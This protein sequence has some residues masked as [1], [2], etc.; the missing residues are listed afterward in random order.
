MADIFLSFAHPDAERVGLLAS[1][2]RRHG[3]SVSG[4]RSPLSG[5]GFG[6]VLESEIKAASVVIVVWSPHS[7]KSDW[8]NDEAWYA[9]DLGKLIPLRIGPAVT[10]T[11]FEMLAALDFSDWNG[12]QADPVFLQLLRSLSARIPVR[13]VEGDGLSRKTPPPAAPVAD[14]LPS[15]AFAI[16]AIFRTGLANAA[17]VLRGVART[18]VAVWPAGRWIALS[19]V[20]LGGLGAGLAFV[21]LA[22]ENTNAPARAAA[23]PVTSAMI[24]KDGVRLVATAGADGIA[25]VYR[26]DT[27]IGNI[28]GHD[29]AISSIAFAQGGDLVVTGDAMGATQVTQVGSLAVTGLLDDASP[30]GA[31]RGFAWDALEPASAWWLAALRAALP[32]MPGPRVVRLEFDALDLG[33]VGGDA[34][35]RNLP[36]AI[37][38]GALQPANSRLAVVGGDEFAFVLKP[39]AFLMQRNTHNAVAAFTLRFSEPV[40]GVGFRLSDVAPE[41][42]GGL[43]FPGW[44]VSAYDAAG[45]VVAQLSGGLARRYADP[46]APGYVLRPAAGVRIVAVRFLSDP[47][48]RGGLT[49]DLPAVPITQISVWRAF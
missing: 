28:R 22:A 12:R 39:A 5:P 19:L 27:L 24:E 8:V 32:G 20:G 31:L 34:L 46:A 37:G 38:I 6:A 41:E 16:S 47:A 35:A 11:G 49:P 3:Y 30:T 36:F 48:A 18:A 17:P 9:K 4:D 40:A 7:V 23:T 42:T 1:L 2:L 26:G 25:R 10:P 14:R 15:A 29:A 43:T 33:P 44:S 21:G 13:D 45:R